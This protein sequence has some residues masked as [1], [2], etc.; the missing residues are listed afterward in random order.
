MP[1]K[2]DYQ[3]AIAEKENEFL[4]C[5]SLISFRSAQKQ[6]CRKYQRL[7]RS[8]EQRRSMIALF[9]V[10]DSTAYFPLPMQ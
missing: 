8:A 1:N 10:F 4:L 5:L 9:F 3:T 7:E 6:H 2:P